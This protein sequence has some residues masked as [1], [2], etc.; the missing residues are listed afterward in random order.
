MRN[1]ETYSKPANYKGEVKHDKVGLAEG[2]LLWT[3]RLRYF[4][5]FLRLLRGA[6]GQLEGLQWF[7]VRFWRWNFLY[8]RVNLRVS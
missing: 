3:V 1:F 5:L 6:E 2:I 4:T 8:S 7:P